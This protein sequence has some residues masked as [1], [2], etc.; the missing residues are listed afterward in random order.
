MT[1][2]NKFDGNSCFRS[3]LRRGFTLR[4][5]FVAI[6]AISILLSIA[7]M[8]PRRGSGPCGPRVRC[9]SNLKLISSAMMDHDFASQQMPGYANENRLLRA[10]TGYVPVLFDRMGMSDF[11]KDWRDGFR[12]T[13]YVHRFVCPDFH[14]P[15]WDVSD[16]T[17]DTLSYVVNGGIVD[18]RGLSDDQIRASGVCFDRVTNRRRQLAVGSRYLSAHDGQSSTLLISENL[19]ADHWGVHI[20]AEAKALNAF[21]WWPGNEPGES[22]LRASAPLPASKTPTILRARPSSIHEGGVNAAFCDG[23]VAFIKDDIDYTVYRQ[24]MTSNSKLWP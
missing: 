10:P 18:I 7:V 20:P 12:R 11:T 19:D 9:T 4:D 1:M 15:P 13:S 3:A 21:V 17:R 23:H 5:M 2:R 14:K 6:T 8:R 16:K 22:H 24:L